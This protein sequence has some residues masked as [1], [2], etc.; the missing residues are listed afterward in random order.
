M[1]LLGTV[2]AWAGPLLIA[3]AWL[4]VRRGR[5]SIWVAMAAVAG[6]LGAA[7]LVVGVRVE[8]ELGAAVE[9]GVGIGAGLALYG[10]TAAFM[11]LFRDWPVLARHT[12]EVYAWREGLPLWAALVLA[13]L[14]VAPGEELLW[15]GVVQGRLAGPLS[16]TAAAVACWG[17]YVAVNAVAGSLPILLGAAVGGAAWGALALWTDGVVASI[18]CHA[19]WTGL[20]VA[21][22]PVFRREGSA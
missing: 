17:A 14:V 8:G 7:S 9:A 1:D 5:V 20:M 6:P 15:R 19:V 18:L 13:S 3:G 11:Y 10:A 12:G 21:A 16:A 22:P 2:V 4:A